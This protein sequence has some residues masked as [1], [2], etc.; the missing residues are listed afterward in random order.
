MLLFLTI[1]NSEEV[2]GARP[3]VNLLRIGREHLKNGNDAEVVVHREC[4]GG[5]GSVLI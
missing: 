3:S 5:R 2:T 4:E 1:Y